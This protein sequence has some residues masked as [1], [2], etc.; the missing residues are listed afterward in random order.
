[1][2]VDDDEYFSDLL[3]PFL[4]RKG[5]KVDTANEGISAIRKLQKS[6]YNAV[7]LDRNLPD[8]KGDDIL[9]LLKMRRRSPKVIM[10]SGDSVDNE[11]KDY[12]SCA[13]ADAFLEKPFRV[14]KLLRLIE[15]N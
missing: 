13:G 8:L 7:L 2:L 4:E 15:S 10:I 9:A 1:M 12:M 3:V 5:Y 11:D 14:E 6:E